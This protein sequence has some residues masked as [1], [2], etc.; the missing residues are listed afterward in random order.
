[1]QMKPR[2][3][4]RS[5]MNHGS[6]SKP[7]RLLEWRRL[8]R[9]DER[10]LRDLPLMEPVIDV[11]AHLNDSLRVKWRRVDSMETLGELNESAKSRCPVCRTIM[12][13]SDV[14]TIVFPTGHRDEVARYVCVGCHVETTKLVDGDKSSRL[15]ARS[16]MSEPARSSHHAQN[17]TRPALPPMNVEADAA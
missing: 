3:G 17:A 12:S 11:G 1:M 5:A 4:S 6:A 16:E 8:T 14:S 15:R 10:A 7:R 9:S 2:T 13:C